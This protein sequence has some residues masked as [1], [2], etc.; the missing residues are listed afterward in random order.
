MRGGQGRG[1]RGDER[2]ARRAGFLQTLGL[3]KSQLPTHHVDDIE[4]SD[5]NCIDGKLCLVDGSGHEGTHFN[6]APLKHYH[7]QPRGTQT[8][9]LAPPLQ[10]LPAPAAPRLAVELA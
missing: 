1:G 7:H 9:K 2:R 4:N 6:A 5:D 10:A 8:S 3:L